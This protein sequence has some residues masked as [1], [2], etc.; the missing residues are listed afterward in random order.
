MIQKESQ[1]TKVGT[2]KC[3]YCSSKDIV[4]RGTRQKKHG[5]VQL[6]FCKNCQRSFTPQKIKGK[7]Y[8]LRVILDAL[9][10][11]DLGH[12]LED[13]S[14]LIKEKYGLNLRPATLGDWIGEFS[15]LCRYTRIRR[16]G[17]KLYSPN[18]IIRGVNLYHRQVYKF[19]IH[20]A[21]LSLLLQE[22]TRHRG[23]G[24]VVE[25]LQAIPRE[26]PHHLFR[27][28]QRASD[29]KARFNLAQVSI[30]EKT[31]YATRIANL[32]LQAV[33]NNRLRHEVLQQFML[34]N[35]SVT[36]A[37]EVPVYLLPQDIE[38]MESQLGFEIPLKLDKAL[39]GH[40]DFLQLRNGLVHILDYKPRAA[41]ERPIKQL[42]SYAL[43][44][45]R[46][47]G[48]RLHDFKCAWFDE[49]SYF[50]FFPLHVVYKLDRRQLQKPR[51]D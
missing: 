9:S 11:Y 20:Q 30:R 39:T 43:A 38:H 21:K 2:E 8:P 12:N 26:C 22:D 24:P 35:D 44:L 17:K 50:E 40:I 25:F 42:I 18:Q 45:S 16:V 29:V 5:K 13:S 15:D 36:V 48:L 19:R 37:T 41:K 27:E 31:N 32:V 4:K 34:C 23:F 33:E 49:K 3:I 51:S 10:F 7:H 6:Y 1:K 46:L 28:S 14:H 47:T